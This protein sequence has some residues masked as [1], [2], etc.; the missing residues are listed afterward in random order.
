[1]NILSI[2]YEITLPWFQW[3]LI[4]DKSTLVWVMAWCRQATSHALAIVDP[5]LCHYKT[6]QGHVKLIPETKADPI[7]KLLLNPGHRLLQS[8]T[9]S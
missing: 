5:D 3:Y 1:M 7:Q 6:S 8:W 4:D 9:I 2:S